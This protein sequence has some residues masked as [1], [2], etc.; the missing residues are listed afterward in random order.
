MMPRSA[1]VG[2]CVTTFDATSGSGANEPHAVPTEAI[3]IVPERNYPPFP[4][5]GDAEVRE[6]R[7]RCRPARHLM[8]RSAS[9]AGLCVESGDS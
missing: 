9:V 7:S 2:S 5:S 4:I 6:R 1:S 3:S 8:P